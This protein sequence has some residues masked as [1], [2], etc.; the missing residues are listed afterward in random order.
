VCEQKEPA[1]GSTFKTLQP[2]EGPFRTWSALLKAAW[3]PS[4]DQR[5]L[6]TKGAGHAAA[7]LQARTDEQPDRFMGLSSVTSFK[8]TEA[9]I[10]SSDWIFP[11]FGEPERL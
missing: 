10:G 2:A 9:W 8:S 4:A 6:R 11:D 7:D 1:F 5:E 3:T